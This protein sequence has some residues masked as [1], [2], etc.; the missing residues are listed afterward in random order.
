M[1]VGQGQIGCM[2]ACSC[3]E[4]LTMLMPL[5]LVTAATAMP[6][7]WWCLLVRSTVLSLLQVLNE[8][9]LDLVVA[10]DTAAGLGALVLAVQQASCFMA[11]PC[12]FL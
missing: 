9:N 7:A 8:A 6:N 12:R 11:V 2:A 1:E 3:V 10:D 5:A 4:G